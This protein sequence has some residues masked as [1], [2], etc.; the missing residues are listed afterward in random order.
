MPIYEYECKKCGRFEAMQKMSDAPL[1]RCPTCRGKVAKLISST[2]FQL[3]G[4]GWYITDYARKGDPAG[5]GEKKPEAKGDGASGSEKKI[6]GKGEAGAGDGAKGGG[7][8][9]D[10]TTKK[11]IGDKTAAA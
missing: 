9:S 11:G 2:S 5:K 10:A 6:E 3:K 8:K 1:G 7:A 4:S